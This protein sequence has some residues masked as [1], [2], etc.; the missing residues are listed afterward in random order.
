MLI[1]N[2]EEL[3]SFYAVCQGQNEKITEEMK[4]GD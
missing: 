3:S 2:T 1:G 4:K